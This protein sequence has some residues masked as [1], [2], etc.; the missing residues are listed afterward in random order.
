MGGAA[1]HM[2]HPF[3]CPD[4]ET[5]TDLIEFFEN[6]ADW[7]VKNPAAVKIDGVNASFKLI[8]NNSAHS[9]ENKEFAGQ[10]LMV[11]LLQILD[12]FDRAIKSNESIKE[13][14]GLKEGF[15]LIHHKF[16]TIL[17]QK[18][19]EHMDSMSKK[20]DTDNHDAITQIPAPKKKLK[21]KVVDVIEKGYF[22]KGKVIR[23]AKVVIGK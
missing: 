2:N 11:S 21:G 9:F 15:K 13:P 12:D 1:G 10:D 20:F 16:K 18:G 3:D 7:V 6:V 22:L 4:V 5:G 14:E 17:E 19:L 23:H 8:D